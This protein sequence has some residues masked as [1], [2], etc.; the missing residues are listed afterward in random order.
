MKEVEIRAYQPRD[1][2]KLCEI[3]DAARKIELAN[4]GLDAAFLPLAIAAEKEKLFEYELHVAG[5]DGCVVGFVAYHEDEIAWLYVAP[6]AMRRG[7][8]HRLVSYV[9][10]NTT[11]RPLLVEVLCGNEP[12]KALY[13]KCGFTLK[14]IASGQMP[15]NEQ[16]AVSVCVLELA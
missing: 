1:W 10:A 11:V 5:Q 9:V 4:A 13:E 2:E 8:G 12:A 14:E 3:H 6:E 15:G 7:I 16:F